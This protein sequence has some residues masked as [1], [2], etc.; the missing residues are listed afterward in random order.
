MRHDVIRHEFEA[1]G[2]KTAVE[3]LAGA[4]RWR[5]H[6][7]IPVP[8]H[9]INLRG[10][11]FELWLNRD[12][13][14]S[15]PEVQ[16]RARHLVLRVGSAEARTYLCGHDERQWFVAG[17]KD[18]PTSVEQAMRLLQPPAVRAAVIA[19]KLKHN[20]QFLRRNAAFIRQGEW[21]F[22]P[23]PEFAVEHTQ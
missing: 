5:R 9:G 18:N 14:V 4:G 19:A 8:D 11:M 16:S 13:E 15:V 1:I 10:D 20:Q 17:V 21:F 12:V 6:G 23:A 22:V 2:A 7:L 3:T